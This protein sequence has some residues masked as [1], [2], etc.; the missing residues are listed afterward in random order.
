VFINRL[1]V[2][3]EMAGDLDQ[4]SA[5]VQ[6]LEFEICFHHKGDPFVTLGTLIPLC[7]GL[8]MHKMGIAVVIL[9]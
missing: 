9:C 2:Q 6:Q 8:L 1:G 3:E 7:L 5:A 4:L